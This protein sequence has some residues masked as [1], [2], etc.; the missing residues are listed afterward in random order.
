MR[1]M[2][3]AGSAEIRKVCF[4]ALDSSTFGHFFQ[5]LVAWDDPT[6]GSSV[7]VAPTLTLWAVKG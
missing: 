2:I 6:F 4:S 7:K 5:E 1:K 3:E